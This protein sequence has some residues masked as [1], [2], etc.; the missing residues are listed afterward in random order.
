MSLIR[1]LCA[2]PVIFDL[3]YEFTLLWRVFVFF[4]EFIVLN[5]CAKHFF[6]TS[7]KQSGISYALSM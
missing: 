6:E 4:D 2:N 7:S 3:G 1:S 5:Y